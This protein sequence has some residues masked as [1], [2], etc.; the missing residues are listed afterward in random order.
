MK[1]FRKTGYLNGFHLKLDAMETTLLTFQR[2]L[3]CFENR[4]LS[5][6]Y[7]CIFR[8]GYT[9]I[10]GSKDNVL[11]DEESG[12]E[13]RRMSR[14][15]CSLPMCKWGNLGHIAAPMLISLAAA[16]VYNSQSSSAFFCFSQRSSRFSFSYFP[17]Y[18]EE[19]ISFERRL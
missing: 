18:Q 10:S 4:R 19:T 13:K 15:V 2:R 9:N 6:A 16:L 8:G 7:A 12:G 14:L 11:I 3:Y 1:R 17:T 5:V